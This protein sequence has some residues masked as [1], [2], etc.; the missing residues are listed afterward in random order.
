MMMIYLATHA[1]LLT[2]L[3]SAI[4]TS[5]FS[6][7]S[8][9]LCLFEGGQLFSITDCCSFCCLVKLFNNV[10]HRICFWCFFD[11]NCTAKELHIQ[12]LHQLET[13]H[14]YQV[15][16]GDEFDISTGSNCGKT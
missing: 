3:G 8:T 2:A 11:S 5:L 7:T 13:Q 6:F 16:L 9:S 1:K 10:S 15:R 12:R 4:T 14:C